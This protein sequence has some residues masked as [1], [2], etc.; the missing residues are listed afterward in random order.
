VEA[1]LP[2]LRGM[3]LWVLASEKR[4]N[5]R[6]DD[7]LDVGVGACD[8]GGDAACSERRCLRELFPLEAATGVLRAASLLK[9]AA[10][11]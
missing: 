4:D 5:N 2:L 3:V 11:D 10:V 6:G 8:G 1:S 9:T 7:G